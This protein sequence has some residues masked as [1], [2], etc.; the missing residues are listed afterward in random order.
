MQ[1]Q[2]HKF[3]G[4]SLHMLLNEKC[5]NVEFFVVRIQENTDQKNLR[6]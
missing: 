5:P 6:I 3:T 4:E 1:K 2:L